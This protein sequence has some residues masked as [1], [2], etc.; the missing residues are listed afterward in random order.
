MSDGW[1]HRGVSADGAEI[2]GRV[3]LMR[4]NRD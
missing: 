2:V 3:E 4:P 1:I